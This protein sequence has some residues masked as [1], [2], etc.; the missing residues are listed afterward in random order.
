MVYDYI[1]AIL[2]HSTGPN[3]HR[4]ASMLH[5]LTLALAAVALM[6]HI[7]GVQTDLIQ[8]Q[9][10]YITPGLRCVS[11]ILEN[12]EMK[13]VK[14]CILYGMSIN[15]CHAVNYDTKDHRC[16]LI[17][18]H[19]VAM[20]VIDSGDFHF[21]SFNYNYGFPQTGVEA[22]CAQSIVQWRKQFALAYVQYDNLVYSD[23]K[24]R[25]NHICKVSVGN[26]EVPGVADVDTKRCM[27]IHHGYVG[28]SEIYR[29]LVLEATERIQV[30]WTSFRVGDVLPSRA[31]TGG[32][33]ADGTLL[34]VCRAFFGGI[35]VTGYY[36]PNKA[37]TFI[38]AGSVEQ[39][40]HVDLLG[41]TPNG[42]IAAGPT[43]GLAC[44]RF[45]VRQGHSTVEWVEYGVPEPMPSGVVRSGMFMV[46]AR[47]DLPLSTIAKFVDN[48]DRKF[49][50]A[51]GS[52]FGCQIWG[53]LMMTSLPYQW[54]PFQ[55]GSDVPY[56]TIIGAY[57]P[58]NQ[59]LYIIRSKLLG[60]SIGSYNSKTGQVDIE[61]FGDKHPSD[62]DILTINLAPGS[63]AWTDDRFYI[64]SGPI[65]AISIQHGDTVTGIRCRFGAQWS[66][67][68]WSNVSP[69][70]I[71]EVKL[72]KGEYLKGV[73][74]ELGDTMNFIKF[75]TN[76]D[77]FG[78]FG[79]MVENKNHT[80]FT[81]CGHIH[82]FSG[83]VLW[84]EIR[85]LNKTFSFAAHGQSC[86]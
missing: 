72:Q 41:F 31:F 13:S 24:V 40:S 37:M 48:W 76:L 80:M 26:S 42:P 17:V 78:P 6:L 79:S 74:F 2:F 44:P 38:H 4:R 63:S 61:H 43:V 55:A 58:E 34:Y 57:T 75:Y 18:S 32:R 30:V 15:D 25:E 5:L 83:Y 84:D 59:P 1:I 68:F 53:H 65:T 20:Q 16:E 36:D 46:V 62:V 49:C 23:S 86:N 14:Q 56:D 50:L 66:T 33:N 28:F 29:V 12:I 81:N 69:E 9:D 82:H 54:Q 22:D 67:G 35:Y 27:F 77:I 10:A 73:E 7:D 52:T 3:P 11:N 85:K 21:A 45:Q 70:Y 51:H 71:S 39:P 60:S 19:G 47:A 64:H 8:L